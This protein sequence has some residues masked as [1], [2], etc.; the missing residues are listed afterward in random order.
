MLTGILGIASTVLGIASKDKSGLVKA[1][2]DGIDN[3][4]LS[5]EERAQYMLEYI[6]TQDDQNSLRSVARRLIA[7]IIVGLFAILMAGSAITYAFNE[8]WSQRLFELATSTTM[9][10]A[11]G[12][13]IGFYFYI[14]AVRA[15]K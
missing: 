7:C 2:K 12:S 5:E 1:A 8:A 10:V 3:I 6:K 13:I 14:Q 15:K 11:V 4:K 9:T